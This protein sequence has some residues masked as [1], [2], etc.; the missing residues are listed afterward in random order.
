M[1]V[2]DFFHVDCVVEPKW[3]YVFFVME[4]GTRYVHIL[5]ITN[6]G[7][8]WTTQLTR[9]LLMS[10]RDQLSDFRFMV[11]DRACQFTASFAF[12]LTD[13]EIDV[14]NI[15]TQCPRANCYAE[16]FVGTVRRELTDRPL[17]TTSTTSSQC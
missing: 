8:R 9:N 12:V 3:L 4:V 14:V 10:L 11:R 15:P 13:A 7:G 6:S 1:L 5:G 17:T 2:C 16:R